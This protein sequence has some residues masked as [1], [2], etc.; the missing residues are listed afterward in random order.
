[1]ET[2]TDGRGLIRGLIVDDDASI[3]DVLKELVS[4]ENVLVDVFTDSRL[5]IAHISKIPV[6][7]VI[8]DLMMSPIGGLEVLRCAKKA[9]EEAVVIIITGHAALET[10]I[11]AVHEGAYDYIKK[12]LKLGEIKLAFDKAL[13]RVQLV[14]KN[15]ELIYKLKDT[16]AQLTAARD[17]IR[18]LKGKKQNSES[19]QGHIRFISTN[20]LNLDLIKGAGEDIRVLHERLEKI[21]QLKKDGLLTENE[22][23]TVKDQIMKS[24]TRLK[25]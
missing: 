6:D 25:A 1:M 19:G 23:L 13:E 3:G 7:I 10:A 12:P 2:L 5:A 20:A 11:E 17:E 16:H 8:T 4:R 18:K 9:N 14:K 15:I 22:F 24:L 21:A